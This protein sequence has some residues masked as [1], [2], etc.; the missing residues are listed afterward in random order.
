MHGTRGGL[1]AAFGLR[2]GTVPVLAGA[3]PAGLA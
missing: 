2:L 3:A 1:V